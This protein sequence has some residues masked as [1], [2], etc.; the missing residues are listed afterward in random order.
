MS[1]N[2]SKDY[3]R[4]ASGAK[5][6]SSDRVVLT[7]SGEEITCTVGQLISAVLNNGV[8]TEAFINPYDPNNI[9][10][11]ESVA[12]NGDDAVN[13]D[14]SVYQT[15]VTS[16]GSEGEEDLNIGDGTGVTVGTR[17]LVTFATRTHAS[18]SIVMD[19]ANITVTGSTVTAVELDA[20]GEFILLEW[21]GASWEVIKAS[22]GVVTAS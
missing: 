11:S 2:S 10:T 13:C 6:N 19:D 20:A 1:R 5:L 18:D 17:H 15:I 7:V 21:Q 22:S 12:T 3:G 8:T 14:V 16:S 4:L 9:L